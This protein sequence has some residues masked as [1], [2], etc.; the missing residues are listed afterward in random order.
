M[1]ELK[2]ALPDLKYSI[3]ILP[4]SGLYI[5]LRLGSFS[6]IATFTSRLSSSSRIPERRSHLPPVKAQSSTLG[7]A[8][9]C[10]ETALTLPVGMQSFPS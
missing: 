8:A 9:I 7:L 1:K 4:S 6:S 5:P 10:L 2:T 3:C